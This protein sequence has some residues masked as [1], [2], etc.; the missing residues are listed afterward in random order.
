M[1]AERRTKFNHSK[2]WKPKRS[3][4]TFCYH[5]NVFSA[6]GAA[7]F[8]A[9][10]RQIGRAWCF[11]SLYIPHKIRPGTNLNVCTTKTGR[12][13]RTRKHAWKA[14]GVPLSSPTTTTRITRTASLR[15]VLGPTLPCVYCGWFL[16]LLGIKKRMDT[17][18]RGRVYGDGTVRESMDLSF[19][20]IRRV[21]N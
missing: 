4:P 15:A 2:Y 6:D 9:T 10:T 18:T 14:S 3:A 17:R 16:P 20:L 5:T 12:W 13:K 7:D 1:A 19:Y 8:E 11:G 21:D